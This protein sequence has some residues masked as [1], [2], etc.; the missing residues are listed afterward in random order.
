MMVETTAGSGI[1]YNMLK[2]YL[3]NLVNRFF[4]ILPLKENNEESLDTYIR[5]LQAELIGC[6]DLVVLLHDDPLYL[7]LL[8]I[9]QYLID[10][11]DCEVEIVKREVFGAISICN[12]LSAKY[13]VK[14]NAAP[15]EEGV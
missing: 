8:A 6:Y 9:L 15:V 12:K 7:S 14:L 5:S 13:A 3:R 2:R 11:P 1:S 10:C 4:K